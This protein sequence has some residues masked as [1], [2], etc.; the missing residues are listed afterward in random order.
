MKIRIIPVM[1]SNPPVTS[2]ICIPV[3]Q[4]DDHQCDRV[5]SFS[6]NLILAGFLCI[7]KFNIY[8]YTVYRS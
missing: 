3:I 5:L 6:L 1:S 2:E 8:V 4:Y 7:A